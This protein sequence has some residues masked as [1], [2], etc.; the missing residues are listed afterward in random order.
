MSVQYDMKA[1]QATAL[2]CEQQ[3]INR[4]HIAMLNGKSENPC[5]WFVSEGTDNVCAKAQTVVGRTVNFAE[6]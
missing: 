2:W 6:I 4:S 3:S 5:T 1:F